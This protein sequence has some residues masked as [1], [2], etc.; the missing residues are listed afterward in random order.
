M[1][2]IKVYS[3]FDLFV[4]TQFAKRILPKVTS[5]NHFRNLFP[6]LLQSSIMVAVVYVINSFIA[7]ALTQLIVGVCSGLVVYILLSLVICKRE[8]YYVISLLKRK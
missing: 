2:R 3:L 4:I 8:F 7:D 1:Y 5:L 6:I